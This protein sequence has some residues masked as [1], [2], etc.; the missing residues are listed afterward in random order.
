M[1]EQTHQVAPLLIHPSSLDSRSYISGL[2]QAI[3]ELIIDCAEVN[4]ADLTELKRL[5][6]SH[7]AKDDLKEF[8]GKFHMVRKEKRPLNDWNALMGI[9][10]TQK[11]RTRIDTEVVERARQL[12][13]ELNGDDRD[14]AEVLRVEVEGK[15]KELVEKSL[16]KERKKK[17]KVVKKAEENKTSYRYLEY[18]KDLLKLEKSMIYMYQ[19]YGSHVIYTFANENLRFH[20]MHQPFSSGNSGTDEDFHEFIYFVTF[21]FYL[22]I[23]FEAIGA[24]EKNLGY[25][26]YYEMLRIFEC[27]IQNLN[28]KP[29]I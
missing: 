1:Q 14:R 19:N 12:R 2:F 3:D 23:A 21:V 16:E 10:M 7:I 17:E 5:V 9:A 8:E 27:K 11:K 18:K 29:N 22:E 28:L 25:P 20:N 6:A 13:D 15:K 26:L 4:N 24:L